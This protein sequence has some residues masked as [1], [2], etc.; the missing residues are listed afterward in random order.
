[1]LHAQPLAAVGFHDRIGQLVVGFRY[2]DLAKNL[3]GHRQRLRS[4]TKKDNV[5]LRHE[6]KFAGWIEEQAQGGQHLVAVVCATAGLQMVGPQGI[7]IGIAMVSGACFG[8][9]FRRRLDGFGVGG[10]GRLGAHGRRQGEEAESN[11]GEAS[12]VRGWQGRSPVG[13]GV[14]RTV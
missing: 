1:M 7:G 14:G 10:C 4:A 8:V 6:I 2:V 5:L 12:F 9:L 13:F 3:I 11:Q